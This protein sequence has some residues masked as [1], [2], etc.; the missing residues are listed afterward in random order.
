[1]KKILV[2]DDDEAVRE[3][4]RD[5]I[6]LMGHEVE[7]ASCAE[8]ALKLVKDVAF[9]CI[10]L[11]LSIPNKYQGVSRVHHGKNLLQRFRA[12][13]GIP[14]V[15][16]ITANGLND[17]QLASEMQDLG[18]FAFIGKPFDDKRV[19][20]RIAGALEVSRRNGDSAQI[21]NREFKGGELVMYG[22]RIELC[23]EEVGG[24]KGNALIRQILPH[25]AR[26]NKQGNYIKPSGKDLA[27]EISSQ[28]SAPNIASAIAGFRM[29]CRIALGCAD[30]DVI[31]THNGGG[32]QMADWIVFKIGS[33]ETIGSQA[34]QDKAIV[35]KE[36]RKFKTRTR[37]Q[38]YDRTGLPLQRVRTALSQLCDDRAI[39]LKGSGSNAVYSI[40]AEG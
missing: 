40:K 35:L 22:D 17:W 30:H 38:I 20:E 37:R 12:M 4:L 3:E 16:V 21:S 15:L 19:D 31:I 34:D 23:G 6:E 14:P 39:Q 11:D 32:Y 27:A 36:I 18:A 13:P 25:L 29:K 5:R 2:I 26:R 7:E 24:V 28:Q 9:D 33:E 8:H 10:L 1:M